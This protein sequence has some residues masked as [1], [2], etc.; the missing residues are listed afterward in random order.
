[1][2]TGA[3]GETDESRIFSLVMYDGGDS[4]ESRT[5]EI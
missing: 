5:G 3:G 4:D 2:K 1:M